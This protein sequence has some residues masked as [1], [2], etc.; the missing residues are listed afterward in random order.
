L[1]EKKNVMGASF[2]FPPD[3][4]RLSPGVRYTFEVLS[5]NHPAQ[6]AW[7]ELLDSNRAQAVRRELAEIEHEIGPTVS[8][9][10]LVTLRAGFLASQGL[11]HDARLVLVA[12]LAKDP[13]EPTFHALLGNLYSKVGL[14]EQAAEAFD[15]A[16][17]LTGGR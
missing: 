4:P 17:F 11:F 14:P 16:R 6:Q 7:F 9:N 8:P 1:L 15:E 13:D 5:G 3:A 2:D 10:S 12:A